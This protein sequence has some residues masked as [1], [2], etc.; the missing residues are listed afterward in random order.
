MRAVIFLLIIAII[1]ACIYTFMKI[2]EQR[3]LRRQAAH[4]RWHI[5]PRTDELNNAKTIWLVC[6]GERDFLYWPTPDNASWNWDKATME[7]EIECTNLNRM[8]KELNR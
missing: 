1:F 7:A 6:A 4:E 2:M 8:K 3:S 5:S